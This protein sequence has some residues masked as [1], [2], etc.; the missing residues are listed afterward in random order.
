[1]VALAATHHDP[2]SRLYHQTGRMLPIL[3]SFYSYIAI[4]MTPSTHTESRSLLQNA[5]VRV[6]DGQPG[7]PQGYTHLGLW[8]RQ[9][10]EQALR[11]VP[12]ATHIHFC[13]FDRVLHWAEFYPDELQATLEYLQ[14]YDLTVLGRTTRA[15]DSHP[16]LQRDTESIVN[17]V[18]ALCSGLSWDVTAGSRGLSRRAAEAI[19]RDCLDDT[20]GN[21]CSWPLFIRR[22]AGLSLSYVPTEGLEF[23]TLDRYGA[24]I[25]ALGSVEAW[26]AQIDADPQL[27]VLRLEI[28]RLGVEAIVTYR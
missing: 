2:E 13:D 4:L 15:F 11:G 24:E 23:E 3:C 27:W 18:F 22:Q 21:D 25:E 19:V 20:V 5:G 10:L 12:D 14:Q 28:A 7:I 8:R 6:S 26:M 17:H 9:A 1:M 16:R